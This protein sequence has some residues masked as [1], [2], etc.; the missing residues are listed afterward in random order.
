MNNT[1]KAALD[2]AK[3]MIKGGVEIEEVS[4]L[5]NIPVEK[6]IPIKEEID[7]AVRKVYGN[8]DH[9][10]FSKGDILFDNYNDVGD[11]A[12]IPDSAENEE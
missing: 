7:E 12:D 11:N 6:L 10:D 2:A 5:M 3:R 9:Y 4:M 1:D 8:I